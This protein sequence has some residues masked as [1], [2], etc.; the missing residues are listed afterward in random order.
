[1]FYPS[2]FSIQLSSLPSCGTATTEGR[3]FGADH[4]EGPLA[5]EPQFYNTNIDC[6]SDGRQSPE[7]YPALMYIYCRYGG[8]FLKGFVFLPLMILKHVL[9][10]SEGTVVQNETFSQM[11]EVAYSTSTCGSKLSCLSSSPYGGRP[12]TSEF[13]V[14]LPKILLTRRPPTPDMFYDVSLTRLMIQSRRPA[15]RSRS[16]PHTQ[17]PRTFDREVQTR[18]PACKN[19]SYDLVYW[20]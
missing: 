11:Y 12:R 14:L 8:A 16:I 17:V 15:S 6:A 19:M 1:L 9:F 5:A 20:H 2:K 7:L 4:L 18:R 3:N 10:V 13:V